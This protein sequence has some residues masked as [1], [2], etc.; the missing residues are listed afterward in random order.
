MSLDLHGMAV[1]DA[2]KY[3]NNEVDQAFYRGVRSM[4]VITGKGLMLEEFSTWANNHPKIQR[5]ELNKDGG[6]FR[7]WLKKNA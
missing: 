7:V 6:S 2:W 1:H 3:F 4:K 5:A